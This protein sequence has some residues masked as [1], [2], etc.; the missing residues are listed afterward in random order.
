MEFHELK[1]F[2]EEKEKVQCRT[3][4][5]WNSKK[6]LKM[7]H[8]TWTRKELY[9]TRLLLTAFLNLSNVLI[10]TLASKVKVPSLLLK[11]SVC[12]G[13]NIEMRSPYYMI[14][15]FLH[16]NYTFI[17]SN[18]WCANMNKKYLSF[19]QMFSMIQTSW[20]W[21]TTAAIGTSSSTLSCCGSTSC[22][23][24]MCASDVGSTSTSWS[25]LLSTATLTGGITIGWS[26][27]TSTCNRTFAWSR[28]ISTRS[29]GRHDVELL[30]LLFK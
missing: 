2:S 21:A 9:L 3:I 30:L 28:L 17:T 6:V 24:S 12:K 29:S 1:P 26:S 11:P 8:T 16:T 23:S 10:S 22:R 25:T 13:K 14:W 18:I 15:S 5:I 4:F 20:S 19:L 27:C 7:G